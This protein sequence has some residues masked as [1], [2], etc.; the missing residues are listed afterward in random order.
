MVTWFLSRNRENDPDFIHQEDRGRRTALKRLV[1]SVRLGGRNSWDGRQ[2]IMKLLTRRG[3]TVRV[4][5]G[6]GVFQTISS[7]C[8]ND[9][10]RRYGNGRT[11]LMIMALNYPLALKYLISRNSEDPDFLN[12]QDD[13]GLSA[14]MIASKGR[15]V[16]RVESVKLLTALPS[17]DIH[18]RD[19]I[20]KSALVH[21]LEHNNVEAMAIL[22]DHACIVESQ[23]HAES[24]DC[25]SAKLDLAE[26]A[27]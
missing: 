3:G 9:N 4:L 5:H 2:M 23:I 18:L 12:A 25:C 20:G 16:R 13:D 6:E 19:R 15:G 8:L 26:Y 1:A 27:Q 7:V 24:S 22:L 14:L 11:S 10:H 17:I 21:A